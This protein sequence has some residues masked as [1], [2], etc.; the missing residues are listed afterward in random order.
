MNVIFA[1]VFFFPCLFEWAYFCVIRL[2]AIQKL[3][4]SNV[5]GKEEIVECFSEFEG[6]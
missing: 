1:C 3:I 6:S 2:K 5:F 4:A